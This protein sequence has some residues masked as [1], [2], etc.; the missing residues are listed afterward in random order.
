MTA[1]LRRRGRWLLWA[2]PLL[3]VASIALIGL[4][5]KY[6]SDGPISRDARKANR[7]A[8]P[9][10]GP[11]PTL[12]PSIFAAHGI[13]E[14]AQPEARLTADV[15]GRIAAIF[16]AE[17]DHVEKGTILAEIENFTMKSQV[18]ASEARLA[19]AQGELDRTMHGMLS[20]DVSAIVFESQAAHANAKLAEEDLARTTELA[21]S[22]SVAN[23]ELVQSRQ[24]YA[25]AQ[26]GYAAASARTASARGGSRREDI[27]I[28]QAHLRAAEALRNEAKAALGRSLVV[29]PFTGDVL[30]LK[31]RIGEYHNPS[32]GD[33]LLILG[34]L[35]NLR[36]RLD[37]DERDIARV[38][39][40]VPGY[41]TASAFGGQRFTGKVVE[42]AKRMGRRTVRV[43]D[44]I[45]RVDVKILEVLFALDG[46]PPLI[47]GQR[48]EGF[49]GPSP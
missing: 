2:A 15:A 6:Q 41:V 43:D 45:D 32:T 39:V 11:V 27:L 17:G 1:A 49:I 16:V 30:R 25:A 34:D 12:D 46:S 20:S 23:T 14:P 42:I 36:I 8:V 29:A 7:I 38:K 33:P 47:T 19:E 21:K 9:A 35:Q 26:A 40:G 24:K 18:A 4:T 28:A 37:V 3:V 13:V 5:F 48:V 10:G 44:P 31:A 22:G